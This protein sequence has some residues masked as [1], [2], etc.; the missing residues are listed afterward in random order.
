M[1]H[2]PNN[3]PTPKIT[4][5]NERTGSL[6]SAPVLPPPPTFTPYYMTPSPMTHSTQPRE[7]L[8]VEALCAKLEDLERRLQ[9]IE[10][11]IKPSACV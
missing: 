8:D 4:I 10:D 5:V 7:R 3:M 1:Q 9:S 11:R 2:H 6:L